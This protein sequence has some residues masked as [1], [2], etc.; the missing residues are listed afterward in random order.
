MAHYAK[1]GLNSK[2]IDVVVVSNEDM[3]D[4]DG[5]ESEQLG[6]DFLEKLTRYPFWVQTSYNGSIR[7]NYAA[8]EYSYDEELDAFIAPSP[9][10]SWVLNEDTCRYESPVPYPEGGEIYQ[11]NEELTNWVLVPEQG[12]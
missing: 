10:E 12:E 9:Y 11:W 6:I 3:M 4:K 1:L 8:V 2:V 5:I 7:K